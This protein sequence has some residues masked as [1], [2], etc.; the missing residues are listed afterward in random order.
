MGR[1]NTKPLSI[2]AMVGFGTTLLLAQCLTAGE[3]IHAPYPMHELSLQQLEQ[4]ALAANPRLAQ[5]AAVIDRAAGQGLI[6]TAYPNPTLSYDGGG[7]GSGGTAGS[8]GIFVDQ[9]FLVGPRRSLADAETRFELHRRQLQFQA[10]QLRVLN[11]IR[12][13]YFELLALKDRFELV[14]QSIE[15]TERLLAKSQELREEESDEVEEPDLLLA[16]GSLRRRRLEQQEVESRYRA[17]WEQLLAVIG[18]PRDEPLSLH[19]SVEQGLPLDTSA[20]GPWYQ[21]IS[22]HPERQA[23][24]LDVRRHR[25]ALELAQ[26]NVRPNVTVRAG[27][28]YDF[29][30]DETLGRVR[31]SVPLQVYYRN[32]GEIR[33]AEA[34]LREA[35]LEVERIEV[36]QRTRLAD[37][38]DRQRRF[39]ATVDQYVREIL[40]E[41]RRAYEIYWQ[42]YQDEEASFSRVT[43]AHD[44]YL[45][46]QR[47]Y[48]S[49]VVELRRV[50]VDLS[51]KLL[52]PRLARTAIDID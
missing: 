19:G 9:E 45:D 14:N 44:N 20:D 37:A 41:A 12:R 49:A 15:Q 30:S 48:L 5:A 17:A 38:L 34:N 16:K 43:S 47:E 26:V 10:E 28:D 8:Q 39:A 40:P 25:A 3:E 21:Y 22:D 1:L 32:Q 29:E 18:R 6:A 51:T 23:A 36:E 42:R 7:I 2:V 52:K 46:A 24:A 27:V 50:E 11:D 13:R 4:L 31:V 35:A 33:E